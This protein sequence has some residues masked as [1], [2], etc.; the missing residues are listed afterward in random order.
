MVSEKDAAVYE[1]TFARHGTGAGEA[2]MIGNS[3]RSD[4]PPALEAGA[5]AAHTPYRLT[6][7]HEAAEPP[8][9]HPRFV[10][11]TAFA[12]VPAWLNGLG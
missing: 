7:A 10:E 9:N 3:L 1:R 6:W 12:E 8:V 5:F 2:A 11:L 4:I